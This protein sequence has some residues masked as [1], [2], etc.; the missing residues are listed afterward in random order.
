MGSGLHAA[1]WLRTAMD[2]RVRT[3]TSEINL[4]RMRMHRARR[5][6]KSIRDDIPACYRATL[7]GRWCY[8]TFPTNALQ[9]C[10]VDSLLMLVPTFFIVG[11]MVSMCWGMVPRGCVQLAIRHE[12][13]VS[14]FE[15]VSAYVALNTTEALETLRGAFDWCG[16]GPMGP[17]LSQINVSVSAAY[18]EVSEPLS[19]LHMAWMT[20]GPAFIATMLILTALLDGI[21]LCLGYSNNCTTR[22]MAMLWCPCKAS[23]ASMAT[24]QEVAKE[25]APE[26]IDPDWMMLP[27][28][29]R[30]MRLHVRKQATLALLSQFLVIVHVAALVFGMCVCP[31]L[32]PAW[33]RMTQSTIVQT[34][35]VS[36]TAAN[37]TNTSIPLAVDL[38]GLWLAGVCAIAVGLSVLAGVACAIV[39]QV[40]QV[41]AAS[42]KCCQCCSSS[43]SE[44]GD[45]IFRG[46]T[47]QNIPA[48]IFGVI[49]FFVLVAGG[50]VAHCSALEYCDPHA[51]NDRVRW[52]LHAGSWAIFLICLARIVAHFFFVEVVTRPCM[53]CC[54]GSIS[55]LECIRHG[56]RTRSWSCISIMKPVISWPAANLLLAML[57]ASGVSIVLSFALH[58][59]NPWGSVLIQMKIAV[60]VV[61]CLAI[62]AGVVAPVTLTIGHVL[63]SCKHDGKMYTTAVTSLDG[64]CRALVVQA[65]L[66]ASRSHDPNRW[67]NN[68]S[69]ALTTTDWVHHQVD[70]CMLESKLQSDLSYAC[71]RLARRGLP[72]PRP[73]VGQIAPC[74]PSLKAFEWTP[75][76]IA[77][78][79]RVLCEAAEQPTTVPLGTSESINV[80]PVGAS[81]H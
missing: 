23:T 26:I 28:Q 61:A 45:E 81:M 38:D 12:A 50:Q 14:G 55:C 17:E 54:W 44:T 1:R 69:V 10:C 47:M 24:L 25:W 58:P 37:V 79:C 33:N 36:L 70:V 46:L 21:V 66:R 11:S 16:S 5:D 60:V 74:L 56:D 63:C 57:T 9:A 65:G 13:G 67:N 64:T 15:N 3:S 48:T 53:V 80:P 41:L 72:H 77:P 18:D 22:S 30:T 7:C 6:L 43:S 51:L 19:D 62:L 59:N 40:L 49:G 2:P 39:F 8:S 75:S 4:A 76:H 35:G 32:V 27:T 31:W 29:F 52:T 71:M 68:S 20:V 78:A 34:S 42:G 73:Q